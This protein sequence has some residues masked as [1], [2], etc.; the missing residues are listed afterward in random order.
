[1]LI[2]QRMAEKSGTLLLRPSFG[3]PVEEKFITGQNEASN[4]APIQIAGPSL[5]EVQ[6]TQMDTIQILD[7]N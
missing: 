3:H 6:G 5:Y 2:A 4:T 7:M 1:M